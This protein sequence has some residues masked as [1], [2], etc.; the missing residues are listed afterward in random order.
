MNI[1]C[2][3]HQMLFCLWI[4]ESCSSLPRFCPRHLIRYCKW[5]FPLVWVLCGN[6]LPGGRDERR[7]VAGGLRP[8]ER[9][10]GHCLLGTRRYCLN[11][12]WCGDGELPPKT[13]QGTSLPLESKNAPGLEVP[14]LILRFAFLSL[15]CMTLRESFHLFSSADSLPWGPPHKSPPCYHGRPFPQRGSNCFLS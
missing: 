9:M 3:F 7:H 15:F 13:S 8:A 12:C 10:C 5:V 1:I 14:Y 2:Y 4:I 11:P 6:P